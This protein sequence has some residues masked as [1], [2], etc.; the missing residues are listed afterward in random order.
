MDLSTQEIEQRV[1]SL[2]QWFH[3]LDLHGVKTAPDHFLGDYPNVKWQRFAH[4]VPEDLSGKS[5]LD[6]GCNAGFYSIEM[7]KRGAA[8]VVGLDSDEV[9]LNQA[10]FAA[11]VSGYGDIE[12]RNM[13]VY[14]V[15]QL[16]EKF[17]L[18]IFMGVLYHLRHPLLALDLIHEHVAGD[19]LVFQSMQRGSKQVDSVDENY[20]FWQEEHFDSP[21]YPKM[22]FIEHRYAD[23]PT[24]WWAP[25]SACVEAMLRSAGF[26]IVRHPET[27]VYIC[28]RVDAPPGAGAVYPAQGRTA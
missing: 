3:N 9:Y 21:G 22:H 5:V 13:S 16:G 23:D 15:G 10:R 18:V 2:G 6:I 17:D 14:D 7:K 25:N 1:R 19:L 8:R 28:R 11:E 12:F 20:T 26:E 27:E 4:A 24:N